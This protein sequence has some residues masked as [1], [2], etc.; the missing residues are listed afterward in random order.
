MAREKG[1]EMCDPIALR[2]EQDEYWSMFRQH[3]I[4]ASPNI[5]RV[6]L[7]KAIAD[8][9]A[10]QQGLSDAIGEFQAEK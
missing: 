6:E 9:R 2:A 5:D 3:A 8:F 10:A 4:N 1:C 7:D